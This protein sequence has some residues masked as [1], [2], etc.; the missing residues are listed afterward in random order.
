MRI[1]MAIRVF[2]RILLDGDAAQRIHAALGAD[3]TKASKPPQETAATSPPS[4][5]RPAVRSDALT[6][7]A[8]L[9]REARFLDFIKEPLDQFSDAQIGAAARDVHRDC[10]AALE[11]MFALAPVRSE[12]EGTEIEVAAGYDVVRWKLTG[13]VQGNPP[14]RGRLAHHGWEARTCELP[15]WSGSKEAARV[16][17]PVEVEIE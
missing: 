4:S 12:E 16:L 2:F 3:V 15:A 1:L 5:T 9:Q 14:F 10:G 17:A 13:N 8:T 7:L 11:R 6:L